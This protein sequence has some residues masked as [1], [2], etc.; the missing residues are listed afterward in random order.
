MKNA[1]LSLLAIPLLCFSCNNST[2]E[3]ST[4]VTPVVNEPASSIT[5]NL[6]K[7]ADNLTSPLNVIFLDDTKMLIGEQ[8]GVIS[9]FEN[10][11]LASTPFLDL[12]SKMVKIGA[13]YEERGLLGLVLHPQFK[14]NN[15]FYVYY[16]APSNAS[17]SDHKSVLSEF[18][19]NGATADLKSERILLTV[20]EPESNHNGGCLK[21]GND[22]FLYV[23]LGDGGGAGD[24]HGNTGN[25]QNLN[26]L[27]GKILRID[28]NK[29]NPYA[30]PSDNPLVG[31]NGKPEIWAYGF[32]NPWRFSFDSKT[33]LLFVAD[34]GQNTWEEVDIVEKGGN[35]GWKIMEATHCFDPEKNCETSGLILPINEYKHDDGISITGG[36]VYNGS[37]IA[38]LTGKYVF[39]DWSGPFYFL[40]KSG[41]KWQRGTIKIGNKPSED[42][43]ILSFAEDNAGELYVLTNTAGSPERGKGAIYRFSK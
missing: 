1:V 12:R 22:G 27:L 14:T 10:G 17:G 9:L 26:T 31:K 2:S 41:D 43:K 8:H 3:D 23:S 37:S 34:V 28:I 11:K 7:I 15:K 39:A 33:N 25:G 21:F 13:S 35:Y 16:S 30:V 4:S 5:L 29:G 24:K 40:Q 36:Y 42:L 38:G 19:S 32:R 20:E 18:I 6:V